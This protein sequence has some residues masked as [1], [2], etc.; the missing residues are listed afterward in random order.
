MAGFPAGADRGHR[1][2]L[3][4]DRAVRCPRQLAD[5]D[6]QS[7]HHEAGYPRGQ[8]VPQALA[9]VQILLRAGCAAVLPAVAP[10][11]VGGQL[12]VGGVPVRENGGFRHTGMTGEG[13][14]DLGR[15]DAEAAHLDLAVRAPDDLQVLIRAPASDVSG[16]VHPAAGHGAIRI[17]QEP[18]GGE[19]R[20]AQVPPGD[21]AATD[22]DLALHP[23]R[24]RGQ[25][26]AEHEH[27][28][29]RERRAHRHP[30][31]R[32]PRSRVPWHREQGGR[33]RHLGQPVRVQE[34][35]SRRRVHGR[36]AVRRHGRLPAG[37][38]EPDTAQPCVARLRDRQQLVPVHGRQVRD[39]DVLL[40]EV[41]E[42]V[43]G[44][45]RARWRQH[46]GGPAEQR[47]QDLLH[48]RVKAQRSEL[49]HAVPCRDLVLA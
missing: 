25:R 35:R 33:D 3:P 5:L 42:K 17:R 20:P 45:H 10:R 29:M 9:G 22:V 47:D 30:A 32:C 46:Q 14:F 26:V 1:E 44:G 48:R 24:N 19:V 6:E 27:L 16:P 4:V 13:A 12:A 40:L 41:A 34:D 7:G 8:E 21:A 38:H 23:R 43:G 39:R 11:V 28:G 37:D 15:L 49:E 31:G 18:L 36:R 2:S